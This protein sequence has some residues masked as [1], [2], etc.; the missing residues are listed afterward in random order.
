MVRPAASWIHCSSWYWKSWCRPSCQFGSRNPRSNALAA[1]CC[2]YVLPSRPAALIAGE[3]SDVASPKVLRGILRWTA[4][5]LEAA[6]A[7]QTGNAKIFGSKQDRNLPGGEAGRKLPQGQKFVCSHVRPDDSTRALRSGV[8]VDV[9]SLPWQND[10]AAALIFQTMPILYYRSC[11]GRWLGP[12]QSSNSSVQTFTG[13][14]ALSS[15]SLALSSF[16]RF[17]GDRDQ[18]PNRGPGLRWFQRLLW[19]PIAHGGAER[20]WNAAWPSFNA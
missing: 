20:A 18:Q 16:P 19:P 3:Q 17:S 10:P 14:W 15:L 6:A 5:R 7:D 12:D 4:D 8:P 13:S 2:H 1:S 9:A 11:F